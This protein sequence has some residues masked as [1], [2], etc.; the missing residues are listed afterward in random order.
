MAQQPLVIRT[1]FSDDAT[2]EAIGEAITAPNEDGIGADAL[3]VDDPGLA[4]LEPAGVLDL[5]PGYASFRCTPA[6]MGGVLNN[7]SIANMDFRDFADRV[8]GDGIFRGF[9]AT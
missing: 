4:G 1:D 8:A 9:A 7:L 2:W 5:H 3:F 6:G